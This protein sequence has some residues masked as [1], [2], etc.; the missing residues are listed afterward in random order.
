MLTKFWFHLLI[1]S[2]TSSFKIL[3]LL[4]FQISIYQ[5]S[6]C[7]SSIL[8]SFLLMFSLFFS[9]HFLLPFSKS[10]SFPVLFLN[11]S[12][13]YSLNKVPSFFGFLIYIRNNNLHFLID[14]AWFKKLT[15][16]INC[17]FL[18]LDDA[19]IH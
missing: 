12:F 13:H 14:S 18:Y 15:F 16:A 17:L 7:I 8:L 6:I 2:W 11:F 3:N 5:Y 19:W 10:Q 9:I 1:N 4:T